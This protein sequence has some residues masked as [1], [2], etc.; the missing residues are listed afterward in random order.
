MFIIISHIFIFIW[1]QYDIENWYHNN[2]KFY[3]VLRY[4]YNIVMMLEKDII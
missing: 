2:M 3:I 4:R 1:Y